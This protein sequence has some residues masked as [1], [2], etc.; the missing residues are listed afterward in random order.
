MRLYAFFMGIM[1]V[2]HIMEIYVV[3]SMSE[4]RALKDRDMHE[5]TR[6]N[7]HYSGKCTSIVDHRGV[8]EVVFIAAPD[9]LVYNQTLLPR[10]SGIVMGLDGTGEIF[11]CHANKDA[12]DSVFLRTSPNSFP[13]YFVTDWRKDDVA[14]YDNAILAIQ[15]LQ[16]VWSVIAIALFV[17]H[18][19]DYTWHGFT[20]VQ[21]K[22]HTDVT[23]PSKATSSQ[24]STEPPTTPSDFLFVKDQTTNH[25]T[26]RH[27]DPRFIP[28]IPVDPPCAPDVADADDVDAENKHID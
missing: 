21:M 12:A 25:L 6:R 4:L 18:A 1:V 5:F 27:V 7:T 16:I 3:M 8:T 28:S 24:V 23:V 19:V 9:E 2:T 26:D 20:A 11:A 14:F 15:R 22:P 17:A 10:R 13:I